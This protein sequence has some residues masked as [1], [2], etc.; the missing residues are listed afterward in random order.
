MCGYIETVQPN[1]FLELPPLFSGWSRYLEACLVEEV[2]LSKAAA[3]TNA[4]DVQRSAL[5][6]LIG[7]IDQLNPFDTREYCN[8]LAIRAAI[9]MKA[10]SLNLWDMTNAIWDSLDLHIACPDVELTLVR[11][12]SVL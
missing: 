7:K 9:A 4:I 2:D 12:Y 8:G 1:A 11:S 3:S 5:D 6:Q 10:S